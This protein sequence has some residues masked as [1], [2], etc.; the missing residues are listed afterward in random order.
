MLFTC[1]KCGKKRD[2]IFKQ[3]GV[4]RYLCWTCLDK[5]DRELHTSLASEARQYRKN[6]RIKHERS[7]QQ[8]VLIPGKISTGEEDLD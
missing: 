8:S 2:A 6:Q 4:D 3:M 7:S 5:D 1:E